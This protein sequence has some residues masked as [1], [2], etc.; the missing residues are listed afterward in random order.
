M[1]NE[2]KFLKGSYTNWSGLT[3]KDAHSFYIV[4][5]RDESDAFVKYELYLGDKF[6]CDGVS[7]A[8][9]ATAVTNLVNGATE[10]YDTLGGLEAK[11]KKLETAVGEGGS[12]AAQI[13]AAIEKL[14][15]SVSATSDG[16]FVTVQ[17]TETDGKLTA[18]AVTTKDIA[19]ASELDALEAAVGT[20]FT[21]GATVAD[22]IAANKKAIEDEADAREQDVADAKKALLGNAAAEYNTL[23]K[24]EDKVLAVEAA[25]KSYEIKAVTKDLGA[26]VKEAF[27]LFDEDGTQAGATINIY[28]DSAL[29]S[30][31]LVSEK[32]EE[33][34]EGEDGYVPSE[35]GQFLKFTYLTTEGKE[36]V[37]YINVSSFLSESEFGDGLDVSADGVV[38]VNVAVATKE[39]ADATVESG[40]NFLKLETDGDGNKALAV[41]SVDTDS[42][43]LQKNI[44]VAGMTDQFGA[45]NYKNNDVIPAGTDIYTILQNILCKELYPT[46]VKSTQGNITSS[47]AQPTIDLS[48]SGTVT[49]GTP[50]TLNSVTCGKLT[51]TPSASKVTGLTYGYSSADDDSADS[52]STTIT[53]NV[54][55]SITDATYDL[56]VSFTGFNGQTSMTATG[57][58]KDECKIESTALDFITMG[59]N[60]ISVTQTGP[61]VKG[62]IEKIESGY[63]VSNL[64]N[65]DASKTYDAVA[66]LSKQLDRPT[67]SNS[68]TITGVLPCFYNLSNGAL[69]DNATVQMSLITG[70]TFTDISVPSEG[71]AKKHFMFDFP[72]DRTVSTF[73]V[74]DLQGNYVTFE[75]AYTQ[76]TE[77]EKEINGI[78]MNY[79]RLQ[80][81]GDFVGDGVY[82]IE[83]S[84]NLNTA[85]INDVVKNN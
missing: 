38:S 1:A 74:K 66:A 85:T 45:G 73:K 61:A 77:V 84:K 7:K 83:L 62:E 42:T 19:K 3:T 32:P 16:E 14:D 37:V 20:G 36:N 33:G 51:V 41:R 12:V 8:D 30:V 58:G 59:E 75:A 21:S 40:K 81:T 2:L 18:V 70:K 69:V 4:E 52:T 17:V 43:I 24:L 79:K 13:T 55:S 44:V 28:K 48:K 71:V 47:V 64:G 82:R 60:K 27:A 53:K 31:E 67:S 50:C 23:G 68:K 65:T 72:A 11:V 57:E 63:T 78:K 80:T 10:G 15:A 35:Q 26:N 5:H 34:V 76:D 22:A 39:N 46:A 49:Y 29:K 25:A 6:L 54:T 9:L 56:A